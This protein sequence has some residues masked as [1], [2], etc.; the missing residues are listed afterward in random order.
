LNRWSLPVYFFILNVLSIFF[1]YR[2]LNRPP[3]RK[4]GSFTDHFRSAFGVTPG[5]EEII[6][7]LLK[8]ESSR[9]I[10]DQLSLPVKAV[11]NHLYNIYHK[12]GVRN[13]VQLSH[14]IRANTLD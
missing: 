2:Y 11:E 8:G 9:S 3:Y 10:G 13:Q 5:E 12:L 7:M 4:H 1:A 14:L 6:V